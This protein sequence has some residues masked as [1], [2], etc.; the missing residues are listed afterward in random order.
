[1]MDENMVT[2]NLILYLFDSVSKKEYSGL[3]EYRT[4][5][6]L[7]KLKTELSEDHPLKESLPY[8]WYF[9]G[10]YSE[11]VSAQIN[12]LKSD[13]IR[14]NDR[15]LFY[16]SKSLKNE[17]IFK[18]ID[19]EVIDIIEKLL[20]PRVFYNIDRIVYEKNAPYEFMP[21]YK[22]KFI[23]EL[24]KYVKSVEKE[25][26]SLELFNDLQDIYYELKVTLP[27]EQIFKDFNDLFL[28]FTTDLN[29]IFEYNSDNL[30]YLKRTLNTTQRVWKTFAYGIRINHHDK[31]YD[32][33]I[34]SW[35]K[36]FF[37]DLNKLKTIVNRFDNFT[38][39]EITIEE[40]EFSDISKKILSSTVGNYKL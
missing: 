20:E 10:P 32:N 8:Y 18:I 14:S 28:I 19:D 15:N 1:M 24:D 7:F 33:R 26:K 22:L 25:D 4:H 30:H 6:L 36:I 23:K 2:K 37:S 34:E 31:Y 5:K 35:K 29:R 40:I 38:I 39:K 12:K 11:I 17:N 9:H 27:L 16:L 21:L 3:N 13:Y